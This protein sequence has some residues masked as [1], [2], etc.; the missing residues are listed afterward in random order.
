MSSIL[1]LVSLMIG[2]V[3]ANPE[4]T[5][6]LPGGAEIE[7]VWIEP[8]TFMMG[9]DQKYSKYSR[10]AGGT[11]PPHQV[12]ITQGFWIGKY[13]VTRGQWK[14]VSDADVPGFDDDLG[15]Y[16]RIRKELEASIRLDYPI[17]SMRRE[18]AQIFTRK[19]CA[20]EGDS[21]AYQYRFAEEDYKH[22]TWRLPTEAE[23]EYACRAGTT[24]DWF[25]GDDPSRFGDYALYL[26]NFER[27]AAEPGGQKLPN[28]WGLYDIFGNVAEW[29][30]DR[31]AP[32]PGGD[33]VDPLIT[34]KFQT[35]VGP[36]SIKDPPDYGY[37]FVHRGG[38]SSSGR[39]RVVAAS[40]RFAACAIWAGWSLGFRVVRMGDA[41]PTSVTPETWGQI[42]KTH[43]EP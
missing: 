4:K 28:P 34:E 17:A 12:T 8:G 32:Y 20:A 19:I 7:M 37:N 42:K 22:S 21:G 29:C 26:G 13:E 35:N 5:F 6:I 39:T 43:S 31:Y 10:N 38:D 9:A 11:S 36:C 1:L 23:W 33:R 15:P 18:Q 16:D 14:S 24:T 25:W 41:P 3:E 40:D 30:L 2:P 27:S